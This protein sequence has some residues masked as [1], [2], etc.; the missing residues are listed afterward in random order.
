M[1]TDSKGN[2][3][4]AGQNLYSVK[5]NITRE[6]L[7]IWA[8]DREDAIK[9][10]G[11][12]GQVK[13]AIWHRGYKINP[14]STTEEVGTNQDNDEPKSTLESELNSI[15]KSLTKDDIINSIKKIVKRRRQMAGKTTDKA[16]IDDLSKHYYYRYI[17]VKPK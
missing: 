13:W 6:Y 17:K 9:K 2:L 11:W 15:D 12:I 10:L 3:P 1:E 4:E 7:S 5:N 16:K 8:K 14:P